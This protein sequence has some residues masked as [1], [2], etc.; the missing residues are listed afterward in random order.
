LNYLVE[1]WEQKAK[2]E[3]GAISQTTD[4]LYLPSAAEAMGNTI[5]GSKLSKRLTGNQ[6]PDKRQDWKYPK[7]G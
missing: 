6:D 5:L 7:Q 3:S 4:S 2:W 1:S